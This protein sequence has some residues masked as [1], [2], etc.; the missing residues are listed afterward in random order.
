MP[1]DH[2]AE[3]AA[4]STS[5][6][7]LRER[8]VL[9]R[10]W[11]L[12]GCVCGGG[13]NNTN[14]TFVFV[15]TRRY[16]KH[17]EYIVSFNPPATLGDSYFSIPASWKKQLKLSK[18]RQ[19]VQVPQQSEEAKFLTA[20]PWEEAKFLTALPQQEQCHPN[21]AW[22]GEDLSL[23]AGRGESPTEASANPPLTLRQ[24]QSLPVS[25]QRGPA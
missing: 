11:G 24:T 14:Q 23:T 17:L 18:A 5:S 7:L 1:G 13:D 8:G 22:A 3:V 25:C 6:S 15:D 4:R 10:R 9:W 19:S 21:Q 12:L 2:S 16:A 20:L